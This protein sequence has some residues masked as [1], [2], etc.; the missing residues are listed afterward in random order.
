MNLWDAS[1]AERVTV[2]NLDQLAELIRQQRDVL[3]S[4]WRQQVKQLPSAR[5]LDTPT[6]NDHIPELF[7]ELTSALRSKPDQSISE[8][9][10]EGSP[11]AHGLQRFREG[12]DMGEVVAEYNILRGC[13]HDLA[14]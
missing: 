3:L 6:L 4:T 10:I 2:N 14:E 1:L 8:A 7:D 11:P 5:N 13:I 9:L 12:Y